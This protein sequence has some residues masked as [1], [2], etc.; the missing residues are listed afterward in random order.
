MAAEAAKS[1]IQPLNLQE[2]VQD[3]SLLQNAE[4]AL[5]TGGGGGF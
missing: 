1:M 2:S 5:T 4:A 3:N